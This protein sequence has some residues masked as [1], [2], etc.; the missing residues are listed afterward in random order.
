VGGAAERATVI[1]VAD[2]TFA[3][4]TADFV[5][6]LVDFAVMVI[7]PPTGTFELFVNVAVAPLE[8]CAEMVPQLTALQLTVQSTPAFVES[9]ETT[10]ARWPARS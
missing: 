6:S 1:G 10:A 8:V 7:V 3:I 9:L 4:A 5:G 2:T